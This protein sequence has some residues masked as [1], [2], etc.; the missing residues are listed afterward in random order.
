M[1]VKKSSLQAYNQIKNRKKDKKKTLPPIGFEP[2]AN[3]S[4]TYCTYNRKKNIG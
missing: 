1:Y 4:S 3:C 2:A